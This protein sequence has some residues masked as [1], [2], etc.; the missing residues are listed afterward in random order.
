MPKIR[1]RKQKTK[2][3]TM[4]HPYIPQRNGK[5]HLWDS[6]TDNISEKGKDSTKEKLGYWME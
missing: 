6:E 4:N 1:R 5:W 3:K 2:K